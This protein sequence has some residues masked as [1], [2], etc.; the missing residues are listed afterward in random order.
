MNLTRKNNLE[1][2]KS[3]LPTPI[4]AMPGAGWEVVSKATMLG[5]RRENAGV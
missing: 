4:T 3:G 2:G 1:G 5:S